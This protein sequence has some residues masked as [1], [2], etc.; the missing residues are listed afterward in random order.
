[1]NRMCV[2]TFLWMTAL[3]AV[4]LMPVNARAAGE[5]TKVYV[6]GT[7]DQTGARNMLSM[8]NEF[9]TDVGTERGDQ[10]WWLDPE[11]SGT[12]VEVSGLDELVYD[13]RLEEIAMQRAAELA[14]PDGRA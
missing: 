13:Y 2:R 6:N 7:Y 1:M 3:I 8:I 9:R 5:L 12:K 10:A 4:F 14:K 11:G